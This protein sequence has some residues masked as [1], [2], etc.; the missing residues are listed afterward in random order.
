[1]CGRYLLDTEIREI[2]KT[3]KIL[4]TKAEEYKAGEIFPSTS[5]PIIFDS[6][7]RTIAHAKWGFP[8]G[9]KKGMVINAR[10]ETIM[11]KPM[12]KDSFYTARCIIPANLYYEWKEEGGGKK[13]KY[14]IGLKNQSLISLGGIFK[15]S[16]DYS[17]SIKQL[18]FVI[19]TTE[20]EED[21]KNIHSRM[22]LI[23]KK[24]DIDAW[25]D[26]NADIKHVQR[27]LKSKVSDEFFINRI[28]DNNSESSGDEDYEQLKMF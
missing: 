21:I 23:I 3:Y 2:I 5:A 4:R 27:I 24:N 11:N 1:M 25:L 8:F 22:P 7:Q 20:A 14:G 26:K 9:F 15:L 18:T 13:V 6:D 12:F 10:S 16:M 19:I 28:D 17:H